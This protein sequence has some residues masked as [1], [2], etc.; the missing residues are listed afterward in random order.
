MSEGQGRQW[1]EE[2]AADIPALML[3]DYQPYAEL[4]KMLASADVLLVLLEKDANRYSVPSK[5]LNYLC[6]GRPV[7]GLL[8][9]SNPVAHVIENSATGLVF[10]PADIGRAAATLLALLADPERRAAM[11]AAARTYAETTFDVGTVGDRFETAL[12]AASDRPSHCGD[13]GKYRSPGGAC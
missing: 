11:G 9:L 10:D 7:F 8:P 12:G 5:V 2:R 4:P 6:A 1:L 13:G 3:L